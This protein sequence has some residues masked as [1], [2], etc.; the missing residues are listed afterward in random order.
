LPRCL[1]RPAVPT[2]KPEEIG[3]SSE[4]LQ[5]VHEAVQR[6]IDA[7]DIS[8]AVTVVG[9]RAVWRIWKRTG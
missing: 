5:R 8:G 9:A 2:I 3:L 7:H 6:H 1:C 4:R